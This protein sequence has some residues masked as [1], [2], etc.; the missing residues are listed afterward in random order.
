[1]LCTCVS[2]QGKEMSPTPE[3]TQTEKELNQG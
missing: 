2:V 3:L 1:M